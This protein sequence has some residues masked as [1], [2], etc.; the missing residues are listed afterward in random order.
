MSSGT[1]LHRAVDEIYR[2]PLRAS[3]VDLLNRELKLGI[4]DDKLR[5]L[6]LALRDDGRLCV[7]EEQSAMREPRILCSMGLAPRSAS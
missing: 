4:E 3:A 6:V 7:V 5:D 1:E 2:F